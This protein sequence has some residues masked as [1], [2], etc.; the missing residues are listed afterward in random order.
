MKTNSLFFAVLVM[1]STVA[2]ANE[3]P[4]MTVV[5]VRGS[6]VFK[7]IYKGA[8]A[9]RVK[10]KIFDDHG[11]MI[12]TENLQALGNGFIRPLNFKGL[13]AGTYTIEIIDRAGSHRETISYRPAHDLKSIHV[14]KLRKGEGKFLLAISNAQDEHIEIRIYDF[15]KRLVHYENKVIKGDFA[16]VYKIQ[17]VH[18]RYTFE[19]TDAGGHKKQFAF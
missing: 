11:K 10:L 13:D 6:E 1:T 18:G 16:Q 7:V 3:G 4:E 17:H 14:S 9:G 12:H 19:I 5:P 15:T 2:F 8:D